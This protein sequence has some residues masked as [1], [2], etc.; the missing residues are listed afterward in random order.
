MF[1]EITNLELWETIIYSS[2]ILTYCVND[3]V[4]DKHDFFILEVIE[5]GFEYENY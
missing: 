1:I 2:F 3:E 4:V 5:H